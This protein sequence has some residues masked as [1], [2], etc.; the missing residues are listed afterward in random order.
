MIMMMMIM[1]IIIIIIITSRIT[2]RRQC[3]IS[4]FVLGSR[5]LEATRAECC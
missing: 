4:N 5:W 2:R 1:I 3:T